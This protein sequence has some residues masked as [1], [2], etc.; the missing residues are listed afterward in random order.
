[1]VWMDLVFSSGKVL[2]LSAATAPVVCVCPHSISF[3]AL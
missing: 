2:L 1:L 3:T